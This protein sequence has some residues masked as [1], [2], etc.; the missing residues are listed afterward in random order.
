MTRYQQFQIATAVAGALIAALMWFAFLRPVP[1]ETARGRI[2]E[3]EPFGPRTVTDH[4]TGKGSLYW[5]PRTIHIPGGYRFGIEVEGSGKR[6]LYG[7]DSLGAKEFAVGQ[8]VDLRYQKRGIP[9]FWVK[10]QVT[11]MNPV[12]R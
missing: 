10:Y 6:F 1:E 5:N 7:L 2:A 12:V 9:P 8:D 11:A 4:Y 3:K